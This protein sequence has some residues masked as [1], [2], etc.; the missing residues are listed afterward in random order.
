MSLLNRLDGS[1]IFFLDVKNKIDNRGGLCKVF[2]QSWFKENFKFSPKECYFSASNEN[3]LRGFHLQIN[4]DL[5]GKIVSCVSGIVLDVLV[6]LR[7]G[8][9]F[10][11][12]YSTYLDSDS[13]DTIFIPKGFGHSFLNLQNNQAILLYLVETE[14]NPINDTGVL[15][16]SV[17]YNWPINNPVISSR[18]KSLPNIESFEPLII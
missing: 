7:M 12:V 3:V 8:A 9:N 16:N 11:K 2:Q 4:E 5:H 15:W 18:D 10:G 13:N 6:D 1:D 17:N 14:H